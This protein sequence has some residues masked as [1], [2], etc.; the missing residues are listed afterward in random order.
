VRRVRELRAGR[1]QAAVDASLASLR[2][3][4]AGLDNLLP[5]MREALVRYATVGEV[6]TTLREVFGTYRPSAL[7]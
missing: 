5:P 2:T 1:D 4:A 3:A 6:S 7:F